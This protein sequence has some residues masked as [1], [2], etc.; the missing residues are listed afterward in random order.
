M[1]FLVF[2]Q[3]PYGDCEWRTQEFSTLEEAERMKTFYLSCGSPAKVQ[4]LE[5]TYS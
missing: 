1:I 2:Y 3:S 5:L 4:S